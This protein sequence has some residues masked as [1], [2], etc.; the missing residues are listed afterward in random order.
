MRVLPVRCGVTWLAWPA[1]AVAR[2]VT[3]EAP[4][5]LPQAPAHLAGLVA[6]DSELVTVIDLVPALG[7]GAETSP[8]V[9]LIL[10]AGEE[11]V[12]VVAHEVAAVAPVGQRLDTAALQANASLTAASDGLCQVGPRAAWVL[13]PEALLEL[14]RELHG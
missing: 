6:L 4:T 5:P 3:W 10:L 7:L 14:L 8:P 12:A 2:V 11:R 1:T 9:R 13:R